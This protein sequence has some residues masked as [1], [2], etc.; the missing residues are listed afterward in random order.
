MSLSL[1]L[2]KMKGLFVTGTDTGVGKTL[3]AGGIANMLRYSGKRVGVFKPVGSGCTHQ[4]EG[5]IN[6]DAEFLRTC[7]H[8]NFSLSEINPVGFVAPAAPLVCEEFENRV[9]DFARIKEAYTKICADS[10]YMIVE[11]I[12]GV[13]VPISGG[14]DVLELAKEFQMPVLIVTRPDLGAINHTLLTIDAVRGAGLQTAGVVISGYDIESAGLAEETLPRVLEEWGEVDV[15]SIVPRDEESSVE[16][17]KLGKEVIEELNE[18]D[19]Q[20]ICG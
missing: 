17:N 6:P 9:V 4:H 7:S 15:L 8:C 13:R 12:G 14:V 11:G 2:P 1:D 10:E 19:W 3:I 20:E 16:E 18:I 5:L